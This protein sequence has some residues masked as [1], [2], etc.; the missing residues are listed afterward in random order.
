M[1]ER[2]P[3]CPWALF[4]GPWQIAVL[5]RTA[6]F[7]QATALPRPPP[8]KLP[9][10]SASAILFLPSCFHYVQ[11]Y[12]FPTMDAAARA[13]DLLTCKRAM[14]KGRGMQAVAGDAINVRCVPSCLQG[15]VTGAAACQGWSSAALLMGCP[16]RMHGAT[17]RI[18]SG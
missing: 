11:I 8:H 15:W 5:L 13:F 1:A 10:A 9:S 17:M 16:A 6:A 4:L 2:L 14:E 7:L 12:G 18:G 3:A